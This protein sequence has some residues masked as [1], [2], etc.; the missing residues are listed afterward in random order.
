MEKL[1]KLVTRGDKILSGSYGLLQG[2]QEFDALRQEILDWFENLKTFV[3]GEL[4][5]PEDLPEVLRHLKEFLPRDDS[6][7]E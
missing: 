4:Q 2:Y 7:T 1:R 3:A 6:D 5:S